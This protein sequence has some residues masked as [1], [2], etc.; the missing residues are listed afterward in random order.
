M[1]AVQHLP[2]IVASCLFAV[3]LTL[4][5]GQPAV[6]AEP[7]YAN[8]F[9]YETE[10]EAHWKFNEVPGDENQLVITRTDG[11]GPVRKLFVL[12][13]KPSSAYK[14]AISKILSVFAN[15]GVNAEITV[16]N[17]KGDEQRGMD[18]IKL[19][20]QSESE[21]IFSMGSRSTAFLWDTYKGGAIPVIS[22]CSKDPVLLGQAEAYDQGSGTNFAFTSLNMP[23]EVQMAYIV[24]FMPDL[25]NFSILVDSRNISAVETQ[26]NPM[27]ELAREKGISVQMISVEDPANA[28][29]ELEGLV[30]SAVT[31]MRKSD[32]LLERSLF[33]ITGSTAVFREIETINANSDRVPVLS[34][35]PEVVA[36]G[37]DSAV[38]SIGISFESNAHLA[39]LYA[40]SVL[41]RTANIGDLDVGI[42]SPPDIAINF[43]KAR[44]IGLEIPFS[45]IESASFIYGYDGEAV[46]STGG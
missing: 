27:A 26:A 1:N 25:R 17:Y 12:Y 28:A 2:R 44:E 6:S 41:Q 13:P 14:V 15:K 10:Q 43:L 9:R 38:M 21:L 11:V 7:A 22:V 29:A 20:E 36:E 5:A 8:W 35:V 19:A 32:P 18:A 46:R 16:Y 24:D 40:H 30:S 45:F 39:S 37:P 3:C 31:T 42:V 33:W 34:V 23:V 4:F